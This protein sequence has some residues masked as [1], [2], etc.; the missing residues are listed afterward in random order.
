MPQNLF[1]RGKQYLKR[2]FILLIVPPRGAQT[3]SVRFPCWLLALSGF[4]LFLL[5]ATVVVDCV[6]YYRMR[7]ERAE[8]AR[9]RNVNNKQ[10]ERLAELQKQARS[11]ERYLQ[12]VR[13]LEQRIREKAGLRPGGGYTSRSGN[14]SGDRMRLSLF[15]ASFDDQNAG[16]EEVGS[17]LEA[18]IRDAVNT[19]DSLQRLEE[20][21]DA[22]LKYLAALP[23]RMPVSGEISS[24]FGYRSSPFRR[25]SSEFHDGL[26]LAASYGTPVRAAGEGVVV[27][28]GY[29]SGYGRTVEI[30]HGYGYRSSYCHLSRALVKTGDHIEKGQILGLVG[31]SGRSTGPHLHF[32]IEKGG[33]LVDPLSVLAK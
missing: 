32:M 7:G 9:L 16:P 18:T 30:S 15:G 6:R 28:T 13:D 29:R 2:P 19:R 4:L 3:R 31:S 12:E 8:L 21:L 23:D 14:K 22:R 10:Q 11:A 27:F 20:D 33:V 5:L 26:D 24:Y 17:A 25:R 1:A